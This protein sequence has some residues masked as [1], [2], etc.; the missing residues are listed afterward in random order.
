MDSWH[1]SSDCFWPVGLG[2]ETVAGGGGEARRAAQL[3]D[4]GTACL[5]VVCRQAVDV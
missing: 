4:S 1:L 2:G 3:P 5:H